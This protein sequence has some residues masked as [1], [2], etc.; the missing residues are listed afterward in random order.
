M[1]FLFLNRPTSKDVVLGSWEHIATSEYGLQML[2]F[3]FVLS[4][5]QKKCFTTNEPVIWSCEG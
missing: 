2:G 1:R 5:W 4:E 3:N